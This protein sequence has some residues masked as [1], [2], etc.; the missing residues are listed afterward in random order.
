VHQVMLH[1]VPR[2]AFEM[3]RQVGQFGRMDHN[4]S[5]ARGVR[6]LHFGSRRAK[7]L[8]WER[9]SAALRFEIGVICGDRRCGYDRHPLQL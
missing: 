3:D 4:Y 2:D 1:Q 5:I 6:S 9:R 8:V 7:G